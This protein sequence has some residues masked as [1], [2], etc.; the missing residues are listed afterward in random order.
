MEADNVPGD[1]GQTTAPALTSDEWFAAL[2]EVARAKGV[3]SFRT[4]AELGGV[5]RWRWDE[6]RAGGKTPEDAWA[7]A[8]LH[9]RVR[10]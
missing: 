1:P 9:V 4:G 10:L 5:F 7:G 8:P 6:D 3:E 2:R